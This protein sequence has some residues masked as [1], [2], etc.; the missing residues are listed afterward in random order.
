MKKVINMKVKSQNLKV[1]IASKNLK[2]TK[3]LKLINGLLI[4]GII[5]SLAVEIVFVARIVMTPQVSAQEEAPD[6]Q[7]AEEE[8]TA[9]DANAVEAEKKCANEIKVFMVGKQIEFGQAINQHFRSDKPTSE[10][11]P[12]AI[13]MYRQYRVDVREKMQKLSGQT[14][15]SKKTFESA[16]SEKPACEKAV[17]EDFAIMKDLLRQ[18]ISTN[19]YVKKSTRLID[20]YKILNS[21]L[22]E[23]NFTIAQTYGYFAA[24]SQKL[25]C[26]AIKCV[27][28]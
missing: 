16:T 11:I 20:Q 5:I 24:L 12:A 17:E 3:F 2:L 22:R 14:A 18:H 6:A 27:K 25:P 7:P 28:Q 10:L 9:E 26:Y 4:F 23:L 8:A 15:T 21:K 19:A 13:E 1:K